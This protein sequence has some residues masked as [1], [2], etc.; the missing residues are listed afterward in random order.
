MEKPS[1][2]VDTKQVSDS[3]GITKQRTEV[4][5]ECN[6]EKAQVQDAGGVLHFTGDRRLENDG[7]RKLEVSDEVHSH[8][9]I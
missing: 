1:A 7:T 2:A 9:D 4:S 8:F 6:S 3:H 5:S